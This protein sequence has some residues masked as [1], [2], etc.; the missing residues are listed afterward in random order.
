MPAAAAKPK[1]S[2][3]GAALVTGAGRRIGAV[4]ALGLARAGYD[5]ALHCHRS[6]A[7]AT[8]LARAVEAC[9]VR[10]AVLPAD[11]SDAAQLAPLCARARARLGPLTLLVNSAALFEAD[12]FATL[13]AA[14]FDA[15]LAVN[16]RAPLL[17]AQAFAAAL[18]ARRAGAVVNIIDQRVLRLNP[19]NFSYTLSKAALWSATQT[20]A[21]ALAPRIRVNAVGP[22][23]S[24]PNAREGARGLA[25]EARAT[26]LA[27]R[28]APEEIAAAVLYLAQAP[29]VTGQM[30]AVDAGQH[31][32]WQT[33]DVMIGAG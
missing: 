22:G 9:G 19:N 21:Q 33:P 20:M 6:V 29:G 32:A 5:V 12:T 16:L 17:L 30:I 15:Q 18:P 4:I 14:D 31:L 28:V 27:R 3:L 26:P 23:P 1:I 11:L 7:A 13:S 8:A 25:R 10:A 2:P 24:L